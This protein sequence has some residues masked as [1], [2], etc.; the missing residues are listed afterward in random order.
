MG[1]WWCYRL[2]TGIFYVP[3]TTIRQIDVPVNVSQQDI[4]RSD[5]PQIFFGA[6]PTQKREGRT[7]LQDKSGDWLQATPEADTGDEI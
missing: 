6:L 7:C 3:V 4:H 5:E 2:H 1:T